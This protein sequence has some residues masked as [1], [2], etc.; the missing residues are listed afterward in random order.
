MFAEPPGSHDICEMCFW[1]D[2]ALQLEFAT[3]LAGG[4]NAMTLAE[5]QRMFAD[6]GAKGASL[7]PHVRKP[8][9]NDR[10]DP[11]WRPIELHDRFPKWNAVHPE[12]A[13]AADETLYYWRP[14]FWLLDLNDR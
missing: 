9:P 10:R 5:A 1:E 11:Q 13:P 7:T 12:R 14:R 6:I 4:A 8:S 2:D 3:T